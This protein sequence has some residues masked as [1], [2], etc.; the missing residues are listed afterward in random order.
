VI[1]G[2]GQAGARDREHLVDQRRRRHQGLPQVVQPL[3]HEG[4]RDHGTGDERPDRPAG[5]LNDREQF[6]TARQ[7]LDDD[8]G[9]PA[10]CR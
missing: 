9:A 7:A 10:G 6:A 8:G 2:A 3:E 5:G 1:V 4:Q